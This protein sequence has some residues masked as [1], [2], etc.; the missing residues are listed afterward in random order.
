MPYYLYRCPQCADQFS[1]VLPIAL[2]HSASCGTCGVPGDIVIMPTAL[3][4]DI[5]E[6][7]IS[8]G[9]GKLVSSRAQ[10][11]DD[12]RRSGCH[13]REPGEDKDIART[14]R[15]LAKKEEAVVD[16]WVEKTAQGLGL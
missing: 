15:E 13:L 11:H 2:R 3:R 7:F 1:A 12:L 5:S 8:P 6:P 9:T 14:R 10:L 4:A 16:T